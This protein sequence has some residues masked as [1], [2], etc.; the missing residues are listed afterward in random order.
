MK[1]V[2]FLGF[3]IISFLKFLNFY[4]NTFVLV[5]GAQQSDS[6]IYVCI[7]IYFIN[8]YVYIYTF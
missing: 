1:P 8:E 6:D 2:S 7:Y 3:I 4:W 5:S